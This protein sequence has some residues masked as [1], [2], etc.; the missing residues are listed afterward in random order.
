M[1]V[2]EERV[3][4]GEEM[5]VGEEAIK[6]LIMALMTMMVGK[7]LKTN[8]MTTMVIYLKTVQVRVVGEE[9]EGPVDVVVVGVEAIAVMVIS[10][11]IVVLGMSKM[12]KEV[13][14]LKIKI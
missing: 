5:V 12:V 2:K 8:T 13:I 3:A 10:V 1:E 9:E 14:M 4:V 11:I 7:L 6:I